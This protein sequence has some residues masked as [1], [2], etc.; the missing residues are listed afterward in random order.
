[1]ELMPVRIWKAGMKMASTSCGRFLLSR[2]FLKGSAS[3][4]RVPLIFS[5]TLLPFSGKP[6]SRRLLGVSGRRNPPTV[7]SAAGTAARPRESL[8]PHGSILS[9][10]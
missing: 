4:W 3:T 7:I 8:H 2:M 5:R 10:P 6:C 9:V 1:M